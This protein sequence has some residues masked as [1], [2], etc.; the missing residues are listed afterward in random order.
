MT[1]YFNKVI[2]IHFVLLEPFLNDSIDINSI[3]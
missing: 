2:K 3:W 1:K